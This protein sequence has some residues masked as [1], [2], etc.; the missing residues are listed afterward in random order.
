[1]ASKMIGKRVDII[2][3]DSWFYGEWGVI[4][5]VIDGNYFVAIANGR[6]C[7]PVFDRKDIRVRRER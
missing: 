2:D 3:K 7:V 6:D 5:D 4:I 1:M